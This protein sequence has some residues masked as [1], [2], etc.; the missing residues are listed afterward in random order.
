MSDSI[1][2]EHTIQRK[3]H[4]RVTVAPFFNG[5]RAG[6]I[7]KGGNG[8]SGVI[9][10]VIDRSHS[11]GKVN[12]ISIDAGQQLKISQTLLFSKIHPR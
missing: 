4:L 3:N 11:M 8:Q 2:E 6:S 10:G 9:A 5:Q 12:F 1:E 7:Q